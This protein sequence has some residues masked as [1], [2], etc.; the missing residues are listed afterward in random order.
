MFKV[1]ITEALVSYLLSRF[2]PLVNRVS[3]HANT[4]SNKEV[5]ILDEST[6]SDTEC[7]DI[8]I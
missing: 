7:V 8:E 2:S 3:K 6:I 5:K 4:C 1:K